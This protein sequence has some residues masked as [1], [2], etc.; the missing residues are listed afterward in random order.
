DIRQ[1]LARRR[2]Y[3]QANA[4]YRAQPIP[5]PIHLF[6]ARDEAV[7]DPLRGWEAVAPAERL[8]LIPVEGTHLSMM[9]EPQIAS[10]G[11]ALSAAIRQAGEQQSHDPAQTAPCD[12]P[13]RHVAQGGD[14]VRRVKTED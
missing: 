8:R 10:L 9:E 2:T 1:F 13:G 4:D 5:L 14:G 11:A 6:T 3:M 7:D 12:D